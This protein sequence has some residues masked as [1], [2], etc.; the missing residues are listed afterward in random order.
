MATRRTIHPLETASHRETTRIPTDLSI[1]RRSMLL[2]M[3]L[4]TGMMGLLGIQILSILI[5]AALIPTPS[6]LAISILTTLIMAFLILAMVATMDQSQRALMPP[7]RY[8][9]SH[10]RVTIV[11]KSFSQLELSQV[12]LHRSARM[13]ENLIHIVR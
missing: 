1:S 10:H 9:N 7:K 2:A 12:I 11:T 4:T 8:N 6:V 5:L 3:I 13:P